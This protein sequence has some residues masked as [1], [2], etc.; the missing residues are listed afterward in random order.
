MSHNK[1][2]ILFLLGLAVI[3]PAF[4]DQGQQLATCFLTPNDHIYISM[5]DEISSLSKEI[6]SVRA[7]AI[8]VAGLGGI[9][10]GLVLAA[11]YHSGISSKKDKLVL[12]LA[13]AAIIILVTAYLVPLGVINADNKEQIQKFTEVQKSV[14]E[15]DAT[16]KK[17]CEAGNLKDTTVKIMVDDNAERSRFVIENLK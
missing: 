11:F 9:A 3:A 15:P 4:A 7:Q 5:S 12:S 1:K 10:F 2:A 8:F 13:C 6:E 14:P 16:V 17:I